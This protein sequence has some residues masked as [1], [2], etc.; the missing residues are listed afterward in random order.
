[1][2]IIGTSVDSHLSPHEHL[3]EIGLFP[4]E[5]GEWIGLLRDVH[6]GFANSELDNNWR[7]LNR[8][9]TIYLI[10]FGERNRQPQ[11]PPG[12][13]IFGGSGNQQ[14]VQTVAVSNT[15]PQ[16]QQVPS[17]MPPSSGTPP[18]GVLVRPG[19]GTGVPP[20]VYEPPPPI[21]C[22]CRAGRCRTCGGTGNANSASGIA[23]WAPS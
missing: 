23:S 8:T 2:D 20:V 13:G 10:P 15:V 9:H 3:W 12:R 4:L 22:L 5:N 1:M 21:R 17:T 18:P 11:P 19:S 14:N 16:T 6:P 7:G